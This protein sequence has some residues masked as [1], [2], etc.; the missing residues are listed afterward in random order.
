MC[1]LMLSII[2]GPGFYWK[3]T[4][5]PRIVSNYQNMMCA[6]DLWNIPSFISIITNKLGYQRYSDR[7]IYNKTNS[8]N[9]I[10][11][12]IMTLVWMNS[13]R[14]LSLMQIRSNETRT[15]Y[16]KNSVKKMLKLAMG[17][18]LQLTSIW[19]SGDFRSGPPWRRGR[20][21]NRIERGNG[22]KYG[23][24][25]NAVAAAACEGNKC[26]DQA[27]VPSHCRLSVGVIVAQIFVFVGVVRPSD[28]GPCNGVWIRVGAVTPFPSPRARVFVLV[29]R[30]WSRP[31]MHAFG[32]VF[33]VAHHIAH[34]Q[35]IRSQNIINLH[36]CIIALLSTYFSK[37]SIR[38]TN[39]VSKNA[40]KWGQMK[41]RWETW[42]VA[43]WR[44]TSVAIKVGPQ[45]HPGIAE[46]FK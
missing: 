25:I 1:K 11:G 13:H 38:S 31:V 12:S 41:E 44:R 37:L 26:S 23:V 16:C 39:C 4:I 14:K 27:S 6:I 3:Y 45:F 32:V 21:A 46:A 7:E 2:P 8:T 9:D 24:L 33:A 42:A 5:Q 15:V 19:V 28:H 34:I 18:L 22:W 35:R 40:I 36:A 20:W 10:R 17:T 43:N 30:Y 29:M